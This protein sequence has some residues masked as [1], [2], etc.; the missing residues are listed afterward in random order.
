MSKAKCQRVA[1]TAYRKGGITAPTQDPRSLVNPDLTIGK[2]SP[3]LLDYI[4][5]CAAPKPNQ[6]TLNQLA[7]IPHA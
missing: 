5:F 7:L 4:W 6:M 3:T 1:W 2:L